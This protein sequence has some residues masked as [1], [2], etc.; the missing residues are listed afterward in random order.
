MANSTD[1]LATAAQLASL[2]EEMNKRFN[3][4]ERRFVTRDQLDEKLEVV[5]ITVLRNVTKLMQTMV[6]DAMT[7]AM[8]EFVTTYMDSP[9]REAEAKEEFVRWLAEQREAEAQAREEAREQTVAAVRGTLKS[10]GRGVAWVRDVALA[11]IA[12]VML[13]SRFF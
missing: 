8:S 3:T 1:D 10:A 12:I 4:L 2:R 5:P 13:L 7:E 11:V 9:K 6:Q